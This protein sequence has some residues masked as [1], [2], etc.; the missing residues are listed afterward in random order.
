ML[1]S[2]AH[3]RG[4]RR[5]AGD[6]GLDSGRGRRLGNPLGDRCERF[7]A[8]GLARHSYELHIDKCCLRIAAFRRASGERISPEIADAPNMSRILLELANQAIVIS[9]RIVSEGIVALE[10]YRCSAPGVR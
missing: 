10:D 7:V 6:V 4:D 2:A 8:R 1:G 5:G 9:V 3:I